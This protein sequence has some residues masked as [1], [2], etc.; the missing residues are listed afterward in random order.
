MKADNSRATFQAM[1]RWLCEPA[2]IF[3]AGL[4]GQLVGVIFARSD[5]RE[6]RLNAHKTGKEEK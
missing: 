4:W 1:G 6:K 5:K 2:D 3:K